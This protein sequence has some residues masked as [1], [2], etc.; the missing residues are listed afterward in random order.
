MKGHQVTD[1][2]T[3]LL[4]KPFLPLGLIFLFALVQTSRF[5]LGRDNL[6]LTVGSC[7]SGM[8]IFAHSLMAF[9]DKGKKSWPLTFLALAGFVPFAFG[10]YL[11]FYKGFW[12][13]RDLFV[14]FSVGRL[15]ARLMFIVLGYQ[16]VNGFYRVTEFVE[17]VARKEVIIK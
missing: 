9:A 5:G 10:C 1:L 8:I 16:V 15:V 2:F 4:T 3:E 17:K 13:L 11:V 12:G 7:L 14:R 6:I